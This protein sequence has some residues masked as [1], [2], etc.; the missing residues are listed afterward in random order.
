MPELVRD[1]YWYAR[2]LAGAQDHYNDV[3]NAEL[4]KADALDDI[5]D[6]ATGLVHAQPQKTPKPKKKKKKTKSP[7]KNLAG[8][9]E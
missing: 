2:S 9:K 1:G 4:D 3:L 8:S 5:D 7:K 6:E